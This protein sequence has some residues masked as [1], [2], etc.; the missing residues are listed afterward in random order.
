MLSGV[1]AN[2]DRSIMSGICF[3]VLGEVLFDGVEDFGCGDSAVGG[4]GAGS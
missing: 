3:G 1:G 4:D 2:Q